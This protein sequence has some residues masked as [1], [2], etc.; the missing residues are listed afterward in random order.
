MEKAPDAVWSATNP[1]V[2][3][4]L[5]STEVEAAV[6]E[7]RSNR[8]ADMWPA[9]API[10]ARST[11]KTLS[12]PGSKKV[13]P[14]PGEKPDAIL[15]DLRSVVAEPNVSARCEEVGEIHAKL[16]GE[17]VV[18]NPRRSELPALGA[19]ACFRSRRP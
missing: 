13:N 14:E 10:E 18:A 9:F 1:A 12:Y 16:T 11:E 2:L 15:Y 4:S 6:G 17:M 8:P 5:S 19:T 7:R 3:H